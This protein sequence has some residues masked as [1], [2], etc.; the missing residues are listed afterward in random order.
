MTTL[1]VSLAV[2]ALGAVT[3][4]VPGAHDEHGHG[5]GGEHEEAEEAP[6]LAITRWTERH[7]LFVE[8]P[9]PIAG[10]PV[11]Y[12]AHVTR[13]DGFAAVTEGVF[14]VRFRSPTAVAAEA[15]IEGV[16][17]PGIFVPEGNA[18]AEGSYSLEMTYEHGGTTDTFDCGPVRVVSAP[19]PPEPEAP[20]SAIT[21]LKESQWKIPFGTAW[22]DERPIA[23]ELE[24]PATVEPAAVDQ[25]TIA[26]PTGG[27]FF[28]NPKLTLA[29]GRVVESGDVMGFIAPT[30]AG[31]DYSRL[32][33]GADEA[34][35][36]AE[37]LEREIA[38]VEPLVKQGLL[39]ERRL[40][41]LRSE[42]EAAAARRRSAA[43]RV[44][45]VN[46]PGGAGGLPIRASS[47]GLLSEVLVP[48]GE[49]VE[50]GAP[51]VRLGGTAS[52]WLRARF[53]AKPAA[54]YAGATPASVR[55]ASG[56]RVDLSAGRAH[57]LS[58]Q[59]VVDPTSRIATWIV[60]VSRRE[61]TPPASPDLRP[62]ASV[63]LS[64]RLGE[65]RPALSVPREAVIDINTRTYVFVQVDGEHFE[66]RAVSLGD[67]DGAFVAVTSG[68]AKGE[69]VVTR[70]GF[71]VHLA[72][73]VGVVES[74][75]H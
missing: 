32:L 29:E 61:G 62:G 30:I 51:L 59:P 54:S 11:P 25:L 12:H 69:R 73:L 5:H 24:L 38:R 35:L 31:E 28:H 39:P 72:S 18:P 56:E 66:K 68:V 1:W 41:D 13:L 26:A 16:K 15:R 50:A 34:R 43:G 67:A 46:T 3:G 58:T 37:R 19:V 64:L 4:C 44:G 22:A 60:D 14:H 47:G 42:L 49:P 74:H 8:F 2:V 63:V 65:P 45:R 48:N 23:R 75:R 40:L 53:V 55:L 10:K 17:R 6:P 70:G 21:F 52:L 33:Q 71:D 9:Q 20:S 36:E 57:L 7:E 27:R